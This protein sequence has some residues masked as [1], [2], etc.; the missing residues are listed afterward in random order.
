MRC[1][2]PTRG[3]AEAT[4]TLCWEMG[5]YGVGAR[6]RAS[7]AIELPMSVEET[8]LKQHFDIAFFQAREFR[9]NPILLVGFLDIQARPPEA[10][11]LSRAMLH[12]TS[13]QHTPST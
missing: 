1:T 2:A 9:R 4:P 3:D 10:T 5:S 7:I 6:P 8:V 12:R 11:E 13:V